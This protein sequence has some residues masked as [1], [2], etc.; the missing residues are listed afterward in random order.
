MIKTKTF[1]CCLI[2]LLLSLS[3]FTAFGFLGIKISHDNDVFFK[4]NPGIDT[5]SIEYENEVAITSGQPFKNP[6]W[7]PAT[8]YLRINAGRS[9]SSDVADWFLAR[10][11]TAVIY[12]RS[13]GGNKPGELNF[14][15]HVHII[16]NGTSYSAYIGQGSDSSSHNNWWI[17]ST[18]DFYG[19]PTMMVTSDGKYIISARDGES[20]KF[21]VWANPILQIDWMK[22]VDDN[23]SL[24]DISIP[25]THDTCTSNL[26]KT[27]I[28]PALGL[29]Q[30]QD[31]SVGAQLIMG[32]RSLDIRVKSNGGIYHRSYTCN[33]TLDQVVS[34]CLDFL[35]KYP[36]ETILFT[37]KNEGDTEDNP[38]VQNLLRSV[39]SAKG[40][41]YFWTKDQIPTLGQV[42]GKIVRLQEFE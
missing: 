12:T 38:T 26:S 10:S 29:T 42:R 19:Y 5:F 1:K 13:A 18:G 37:V 22:N 40:E 15:V 30:C 31:F 25:G 2:A 8:N 14:A 4:Q 3:S 39:I 9:G 27:L 11:K 21:D 28:A 17:G 6:V 36:T 7:F 34:E 33:S 35:K 32:V 16:I 41:D 23:K 20:F 24:K